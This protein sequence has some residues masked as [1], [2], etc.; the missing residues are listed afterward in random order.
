MEEALCNVTPS[1]A[2]GWFDHCGYEVEV[3]YLSI[4]LPERVLD[5]M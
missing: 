3:Q 4:P 5:V 2:A 1:E